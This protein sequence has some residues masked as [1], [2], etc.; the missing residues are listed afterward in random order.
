MTEMTDKTNSPINDGL[1]TMTES[2][3]KLPAEKTFTVN[4]AT[5]WSIVHFESDEEDNVEGFNDLIPSSW[6]TTMGTLSWYPI[7]EHKGTIHKLVK[8]CAKANPEWNC[9][10]IRKIEQGIE[11]YDRGMK[12]LVKIDKNPNA[13]LHSDLEEKGKG[14]RLKKTTQRF[15]GSHNKNVQKKQI[16][17]TM[18]PPIPKLG[19]ISKPEQASRSLSNIKDVTNNQYSLLDNAQQPNCSSCDE[20]SIDD[21]GTKGLKPA[22]E[23][24]LVTKMPTSNRATNKPGVYSAEHFSK[25]IGC[26]IP[27]KINHKC[28][29]IEGGVA[30]LESLADAICYLNVEVFS[31]KMSLRKTDKNMESFLETAAMVKK[32]STVMMTPTVHVLDEFPVKNIEELRIVER[33]LKKETFHLQ[34]VEAL[35]SGVMGEPLKKQIN[36]ILRLVLDDEVA[37][38]FNW[39]GQRGTKIK[40][41]NRRIAKIMIAVAM[42]FPM[43]NNTTFGRNAGPWLAQATFR[44]KNKN[45]NNNKKDDPEDVTDDSES[46]SS[47]NDDELGDDLSEKDCD[48]IDKSIS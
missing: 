3:E 34:V 31:C 21:K 43:I 27:S 16:T 44:L 13:A 42:D 39:K 5:V 30:T 24:S 6:I 29:Y 14:K 36:S 23:D 37:S 47:E 35:H 17:Q 4:D 32:P 9:F 22:K 40:L 48:E 2:C 1:S 19:N 7:N 20:I 38:V 33:K 11:N 12:M 28:A 8:Q 25:I 18:L 15:V 46:G 41:S 45:V 26:K 10:S